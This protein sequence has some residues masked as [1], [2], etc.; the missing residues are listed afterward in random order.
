[1]S[2]RVAKALEDM[3][4]RGQR[5]MRVAILGDVHCDWTSLNVVVSQILRNHPEVTHIFQVGDFGDGWPGVKRF[6][7]SKAFHEDLPTIPFHWCDGNHENHDRLHAKGSGKSKDPLII[8]QERGS[9]LSIENTHTMFF[10]GATSIDRAMRT[11]GYSWWPEEAIKYREVMAALGQGPIDAM[12]THDCPDV[13][14][15]RGEH[16]EVFGKGDRQALDALYEEYEPR[17]WFY[18]HYHMAERGE[19]RNTQWVC[20][21]ETITREYVLWDGDYVWC[22]WE[23]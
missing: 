4:D 20:C 11:E 19:Y 1:M 6:K 3:F 9:I 23:K 7:W 12:V 14:G 15:C 13:F 2:E 16:K 8:Y 18:G 17:F 10:G 22:S 21:P 5:H